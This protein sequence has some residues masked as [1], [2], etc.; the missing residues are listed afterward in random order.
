MQDHLIAY[1]FG[2]G[3]IKASLYTAQGAS[4]AST[5]EPYDTI[6]PQVGWHEQRPADWWE[7]VIKSTNKLLGAS[8]IDK[9]TIAALA[10]S[11]HS[12]GVVPID[13]AGSLLLHSTPIW[14]DMR[15]EKQKKEFF[16]TRSEEAWYLKTGN[17]FP[18]HLYSAFKLLWYRDNMPEMFGKISSVLGTKDYINYKLTGVIA[19]DPSYASGSGFYSLK[20]K[21][22]DEGLL[23]EF[24]F[25]KSLFPEIVPSTHI[26][27]TLT[28]E[29]AHALGLPA[30]VKVAC[31]GVDNS[32]MALGARGIEDGRVYTSLGSSSWIAITSHEPILDA[33]LKPFVFAHVIPDM[34]A[35][36]TS[37]FAAG[38]SFQWVRNELC[39]DLIA[40]GN[41]DPYALMNELAALSP[42][43][44]NKLLFNPSLAGGSGSDRTPNVRGA[45]LGLDLKHTRQDLI[46]A[47]ME[48]ISLSLRIAL[49]RLKEMSPVANEM[50]IVGGGGKSQLWRQMFADIYGLDILQTSVGQD[51]GSLGAVALAAVGAGFWKDFTPIDSI[52]QLV[53]VK[54]PDPAAQEEYNKIL[55]VLKK[56]NEHLYDISDIMENEL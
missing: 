28:G 31:G 46:R 17:G 25:D 18:S 7:S 52:H 19:T 12:L 36:A 37:I 8:G 49:D 3:G 14:S 34:Y 29:A 54:H 40:D 45:Y 39:K 43:G 32:C 51:A 6:Y 1:D 2:T 41:K 33:K 50:L 22:Y 47:A 38:S 11:G 10:I 42:I 30:H 48:G 44:A 53:G 55:A 27:G 24:G 13:K 15:A 16:R 35:S 56:V 21:A 20:D 23:A 5:F 26:I 9:N 4:L